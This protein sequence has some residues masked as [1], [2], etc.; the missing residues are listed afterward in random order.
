[1]SSHCASDRTV[2]RRNWCIQEGTSFTWIMYLLYSTQVQLSTSWS[3]TQNYKNSNP[4][5]PNKE[6][7][8]LSLLSWNVLAPA[9]ALP[10]KF[11]WVDPDSLEWGYRESRIVDMLQKA[12][13]DVVCLQEMGVKEWDSFL[14]KVRPTYNG[15]LQ[16]M[17]RDHPVANA[18][19]YKPNVV[20]MV[21]TESRS[22]ALIAVL[23]RPPHLEED[24]HQSPLFLA[25]LHLEAG[26]HKDDTRLSQIRSLFKRLKIHCDK[27]NIDIEDPLTSPAIVLVGDMNM[28]PD[29]DLY[30]YVS[31]GVIPPNSSL[32]KSNAPASKALL[33]FRN[34]YE[35]I[36]PNP[37]LPLTFGGGCVLDYVW[38]SKS[39]RLFE[40]MPVEEWATLQLPSDQHPSDHLP[41]GTIF[42]W[43][44]DE[45]PIPSVNVMDNAKEPA[46]QEYQSPPEQHQQLRHLWQTI[47]KA[48][49]SD[50]KRRPLDEYH[51]TPLL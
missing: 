37:P 34:A 36:P 11:P 12:D 30:T 21:R 38:V 41:I 50:K 9:Y 35:E 46:L 23:R 49:K 20:Q 2:M 3:F 24:Q 19:L 28:L 32:K 43:G 7:Q 47:Q 6:Q 10:Y 13:A 40:T 51:I 8:Q 17:H 31:T 33:P 26:N 44:K 42:S 18:I 39:V 5:S 14:D 1:M 25:N 27:E 45:S 4:N 15:V 29:T 22:R 16:T 48:T